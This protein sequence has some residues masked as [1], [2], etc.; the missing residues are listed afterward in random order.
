MVNAKERRIQK[1]R[2][3]NLSC[4]KHKGK[5]KAETTKEEELPNNPVKAKKLND[6]NEK[7][8][9]GIVGKLGHDK[10]RSNFNLRSQAK[11]HMRVT[12][13]EK[14]LNRATKQADITKKEKAKKKQ[15]NV[16]VRYLSA[17]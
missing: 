14:K 17:I 4:F 7:P 15:G 6:L 10:L 8:Y 13:K 1:S 16:P 11:L 9:A 5:R 12:K 3:R 2:E